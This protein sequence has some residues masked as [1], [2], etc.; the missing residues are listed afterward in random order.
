MEETSTAADESNHV[1]ILH[2]DHHRT[3]SRADELDRITSG[4]VLKPR[5]KYY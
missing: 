3:K 5:A 4:D 1:R 2:V